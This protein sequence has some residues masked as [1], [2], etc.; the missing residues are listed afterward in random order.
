M[1][2]VLALDEKIVDNIDKTVNV[3][4]KLQSLESKITEGQILQN[5]NTRSSRVPATVQVNLDSR[6][7]SLDQK[8]SDIDS[9]L[10]GLKNQIDNNFLGTDDINAEA[11]ERKPVSMNVAEITR[12]IN[13]EMVQQFNKELN[14]L[15]ATTN[16]IDKK[17]QFHINIMSENLGRALKLVNEVHDAVVDPQY[18]IYNVSTTT[19]RPPVAAAARSSKLDALAQQIRPIMSVSDKMDEVWNVVVGTKSSV[20]HLVPKSDELLSQT[21]R[22]ERAIGEI[23]QDLR[24]KTNQ[25]IENLD[26]VERRLK[27]QED[28]VAVLAQR[29]VPPEL[30]MD[31]TID[32]LVEYDSNR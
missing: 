28:D 16:N 3:I 23:H 13:A 14:V 2:R 32:R 11:S 25:I 9:K 26:L 22:Q 24:T 18:V 7:V 8:V 30:L 5:I 27:K 4:N 19:Q 29:P 1:L 31:P 20:D 17:L 12:S 21:Q 15:Q 6:L 10:S